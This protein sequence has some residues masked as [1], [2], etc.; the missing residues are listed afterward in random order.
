MVSL[1]PNLSSLFSI[2]LVELACSWKNPSC[3]YLPTA[4]LLVT[5][6]FPSSYCSDEQ[7]ILMLRNDKTTLTPL[8]ITIS[9]PWIQIS[10]L[11]LSA[12][13]YNLVS[14]R[15]QHIAVLTY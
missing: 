8:A 10:Y 15:R 1:D 11:L 5:L 3:V 14:L 2:T 9:S 7:K 6:I 13:Q 12:S 4:S